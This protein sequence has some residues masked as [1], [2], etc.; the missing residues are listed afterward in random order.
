MKWKKNS[1]L[2][3]TTT[4]N[5]YTN[6]IG[7]KSRWLN[8]LKRS[9]GLLKMNFM[10][11]FGMVKGLQ[12]L[13]IHVWTLH[14]PK[15]VHYTILSPT[16]TF[17]SLATTTSIFE[18]CQSTFLKNSESRKKFK[19]NTTQNED[20]TKGDPRWFGKEPKAFV[21]KFLLFAK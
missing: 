3:L 12:I 13:C 10:L 19:C 11:R 6:N 17:S 8:H 16:S 18:C 20:T 2:I 9:H 15:L 1:M 5:L 4:I 7:Y 14:L 21:K